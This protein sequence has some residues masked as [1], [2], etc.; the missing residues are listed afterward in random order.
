[1]S[2]LTWHMLIY[3]KLQYIYKRETI[4]KYIQNRH[5]WVYIYYNV[6]RIWIVAKKKKKLK[7]KKRKKEEEKNK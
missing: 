7:K 4:Q 2:K 3:I 1:M 5:K 6:Y